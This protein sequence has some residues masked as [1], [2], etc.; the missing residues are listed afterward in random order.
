MRHHLYTSVY[1]LFVAF[2][3]FSIQSFSQCCNVVSSNGVVATT[4]NGVCASTL[5][6]AMGPCQDTDGDGVANSDDKC[7]DVKGPVSLG[8]CPDADG[9]K[10]PD[11][12]DK[13]PTVFGLTTMAGCPDSDNDGITDADD[14]C[15]TIAGLSVYK[16]CAD[17]DG[18]SI[19]DAEDKC[20]SVKGLL[21][22]GGCPDTDKDG[23]MDSQDA[24]PTVAGLASTSGCPDRDKD[25]VADNKDKCPDVPG[26]VEEKGCPKISEEVLKKVKSSAKGIYFESGKDV[27]KK[28]SFDDLDNLAT[29]LAS[30]PSS[31]V[32]IEGHTDNV[33]VAAKNLTLSQK[34]AEACKAY[35]EK[36]GIDPARLK[37]TGYGDTKPVADNKTKEGKAKNRRVDF[38]LT[39]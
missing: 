22:F 3:F 39:R 1:A 36:K 10:I 19:P 29:I 34:R 27:I 26:L 32:S 31:D 18:D 4:A 2:F 33:G 17:T 11:P 21:S 30:E 37:A 8:G 24:C 7:P 5:A 23:I 38:A 16:G 12:M 28:E 25:G 9:D 15:P 35:L 20:P 14:K 13:C 6:A